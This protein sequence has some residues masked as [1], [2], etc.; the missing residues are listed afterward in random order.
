MLSLQLSTLFISLLETHKYVFD[1]LFIKMSIKLY[2]LQRKTF[3]FMKA[4]KFM[5]Y[6]L[7]NVYG[8]KSSRRLMKISYKILN[9]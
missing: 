6:S 8:M 5:L 4:A 2:I 3:F 1:K 9:V 7:I